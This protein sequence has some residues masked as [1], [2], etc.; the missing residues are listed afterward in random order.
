[1][2]AV[3]P[4]IY[5]WTGFYVGANAGYGFGNNHSQV[6]EFSPSLPGLASSAPGTS[7]TPKGG[8]GG[9]QF[10]YN[11]QASPHW[12][13]G[14]EADFQGTTQNDTACASLVCYSQTSPSGLVN[15]I[16]TVHQQL[17]YFGTVRGRLGYLYNNTLFYGTGGGA[18]GHVRENVHE[19]FSSG[20]TS[21]IIDNGTTK[22]LAGYVV[23]GGIEAMLSG[24]W[25]AKAEY[26]YM[27][28]GSISGS[29]DISTPGNPAT[30]LTNSTIRDHIVRIGV[31][32]HIGAA[33]Y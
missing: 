22:D 6:D 4:P 7:V 33:P 21:Q 3:P 12:V 29:A 18:F 20:S 24:G 13:A 32:Y 28:L 23:G 11:W 10:G 5:S 17:D 1:M 2:A 9:A 26:L 25:S 14:F 27:N 31:N 30:L 16:V 8:L 15:Q 19:T